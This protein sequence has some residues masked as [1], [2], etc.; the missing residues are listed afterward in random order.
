MAAKKK[1]AAPAP[2]DTLDQALKNW[3]VEMWT[4][5]VLW[6]NRN[7]I[8]ELTVQVTEKDI[9]AW[10]QCID[11]L[12]ITTQLKI[13]RPQGRPAQAAIP[14]VPG[15]PQRP[16]RSAIP[17]RAQEPPRPFILVQLLD[18]DGN[19]FRPIENSEEARR[20]QEQA[21]RLRRAKDEARSLA[22]Q[23]QHDMA[24]GV[25]SNSLIADAAQALI[26]LANA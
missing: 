11:Y 23:L 3:S 10:Q 9:T 8:P 21:E 26:A 7:A 13:Y 12:G 18:Q 17:A 22:G 16:G 4:K 6:K 14:E 1:A 20:E 5:M 15:T 25:Y 24:V 19:T 2:L